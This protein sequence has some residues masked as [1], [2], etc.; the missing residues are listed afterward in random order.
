MEVEICVPVHTYIVL[1]K[2]SSICNA[3]LKQVQV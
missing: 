2:E 1:S 3:G